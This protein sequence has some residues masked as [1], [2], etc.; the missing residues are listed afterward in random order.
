MQVG[1]FIWNTNG[2]QTQAVYIERE[3]NLGAHG[4]MHMQAQEKPWKIP[5][6]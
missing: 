2:L 6:P 1:S 4:D 5:F 3:G